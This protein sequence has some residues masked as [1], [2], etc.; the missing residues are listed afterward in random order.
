MIATTNAV[1]G[2]GSTEDCGRREDTPPVDDSS[3]ASSDVGSIESEHPGRQYGPDGT[4]DLDRI[5]N[6]RHVCRMSHGSACNDD[7]KEALSKQLRSLIL[8]DVVDGCLVESGISV[9]YIALSYVWG[10]VKT[11]RLLQSN[12]NDLKKPGSLRNLAVPDTIRDTMQLVLALG[13]RYVWV[14][15]LCVVQD[16]GPAEMAKVLGA[17]ACIYAS[18]DFTLVAAGGMDASHGLPGVGGPARLRLASDPNDGHFPFDSVWASR[19]W[20]FQEAVFS[21]RLL[22][23]EGTVSWVCGRCLWLE[24]SNDSPSIDQNVV[25]PAERK[26]IGYPMGMMSTVSSMPSLRLWGQLVEDYSARNLT[27]DGD[28]VRAFAGATEVIRPTF[29]GGVIHGCPRFFF[30]IALLWQPSAALTRRDDQPSWSW[31]GWKG[32]IGCLTEWFPFYPGVYRTNQYRHWNPMATLSPIAKFEVHGQINTWMNGFYEYQALRASSEAATPKGWKRHSH[33]EADY[34]THT[35]SEEDKYTYPLPVVG[36][37][38]T[39]VDAVDTAVLHCVAPKATLY[40]GAT[41]MKER[42][43]YREHVRH[44]FV[45]L[46]HADQ[47]IGALIVTSGIRHKVARNT[48]CD[49][50]AISAAEIHHSDRL[51]EESDLYAHMCES[52]STQPRCISSYYNVMWIISVGDVLHR[53]GLGIVEKVAWDLLG[54]E[55]ATIKLG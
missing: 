18:A 44:R 33:Q 41:M 40:F 48:L 2:A 53:K 50:I 55:T 17:M 24:K 19:G 29:P 23:F 32:E 43:N 37:F 8:I 35:S 12:F 4:I 39:P 25:W 42:T 10:K 13:E 46:L 1:T 16:A 6:W 31:Y 9:T 21:R 45:Q 34:F 11:V 49:V 54:S 27:F 26:H 5:R 22:I 52:V 47:V 28:I 15:Y 14:D 38:E 30:D 7:Y 3:D 36:E 51:K 20:T